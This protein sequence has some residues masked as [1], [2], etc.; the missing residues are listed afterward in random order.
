VGPDEQQGVPV[1]ALA[2]REPLLGHQP[3]RPRQLAGVALIVVTIAALGSAAEP[4]RHWSFVAPQRPIPPTVDN[5]AW[6][7][8]AIDLFVLSRLERE[9]LSPS[10]AADRPTLVRRLSLDLVGLPPQPADVDAFLG[11]R[12]PGACERLVDRLLASPRFGERLALQWM[13]AARYADTH[14]YHEDYHRDMWPWRDWVIGALNDNMPFDR[15]T[16][17]QLA[18]DLLP[19]AS[20]SQVVASGFNRNHGVTASG[21]SEEYRVEYVLDRLRT[22]GTVWMGL[23][24]GCAQCHDHK[25]DPLSQEEF[26][27]L[28][29][30]FNSI[31]DKGVENRSGNVDPLVKAIPPAQ[32]NLERTL[33]REI[34][35]L[36]RQL[37]QRADLAGSLVARWEQQLD[38]DGKKPLKLPSGAVVHCPLDEQQGNRVAAG[39]ADGRTGRVHGQP[40]WDSGQV[41]GGLK[42]DGKTYID[43]GDTAGFERTDAFSYGAWVRASGGGAII[44]RMDDA[45]A[46]RGWDVYLTGKGVEVHLVH[47]WPENSVHM[48]SKS[49]LPSDRWTHVFVTYDGSSRAAGCRLYFNGKLQPVNVTHDKLTGSIRTDKPLHIARRNPGGTLAGAIDDVRIYPRALVPEEVSALAGQDAISPILAIAPERRTKQQRQTLARAYLALHDATYRKIAGRLAGLRSELAAAGTNRPTVMVMQEMKQPRP[50]F[51]LLRGQY[52]QQGVAVKPGVPAFLPPIA[53]DAP[54]NRLGLARWLVDPR[55]PLTARVAVN[56]LWQLAFGTGLVRS[57]EDFGTQGE[58][59][60]HPKLLNWLAGEYVRTGW[61]TKAM[62]KLIVT[63]A[64]YRQSSRVTG[65]LQVR[66]PDNRLLA[67]GSRHRLPAELIRDAALSAGDLLVEHLG[68]PSVKPYQ[69]AGLWRETSNRGYTQSGGA[70]LYRRSLYTYWK[71]SVP[72]P[73]MSALD[74]PNREVCTVRRQRTNTPLMALVLLNDSTFVEAARGLAARVIRQARPDAR[75]RLAFVLVT[76]RVPDADELAVLRDLLA[77]QSARFRGNPAAAKALLGVGESPRDE[78]LDAVEHAA[79]TTVCSVILNLDEAI[80]RE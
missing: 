76:A 48:I 21:I 4:A 34:G 64:T 55:N 14:G 62:L 66:D 24:I 6:A 28:F 43:L 29:A 32:L 68:G 75:A 46:Y 36:E 19:G 23:T 54:A 38:K 59:P 18:G 79:W 16:I 9:G 42:L 56:R 27:G 69:P 13:D 1:P 15:F 57:S 30:Y 40:A 44:A 35:V 50:T 61:D 52:D 51:V 53:A 73:N 49:P 7:R 26:Y 12:N 58:P 45:A 70:A 25:Y 80:T 74:A 8:N 78:T 37:Q 39:L 11:D 67:R 60:S 63:S 33:S 22:T 77:E 17:E 5:P 65:P 31:T 47:R 41:A 10:A 2:G 72:P 3:V 71:R 20:N